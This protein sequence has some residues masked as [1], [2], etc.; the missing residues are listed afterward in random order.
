MPRISNDKERIEVVISKDTARKLRELIAKKYREFRKGLLSAEVEAALQSWIALHTQEHTDSEINRP[1][2]L[3]T[4]YRK[5][6]R[7][8]QWLSQVYQID[9]T[10]V[11]Q[12]PKKLLVRAIQANLGSDPRTI[13]K[14]LSQFEEWGLIKWITPNEVE[15]K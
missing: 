2:P 1:N 13:R 9:F 15:V 11:N 6:T 5:Y 4:I 10:Q 14:Y 8:K 12:I 3:P 7:V